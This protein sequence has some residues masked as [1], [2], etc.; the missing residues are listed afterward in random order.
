M[1]R[2]VAYRVSRLRWRSEVCFEGASGFEPESAALPAI[3][4]I[5]YTPERSVFRPARYQA[6][7]SETVTIM[8]SSGRPWI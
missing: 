3:F 5:N 7:V 2:V 8:R 1:L 4:P 6:V